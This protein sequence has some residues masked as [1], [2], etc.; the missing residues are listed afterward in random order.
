MKTFDQKSYDLA[1]HFLE[2]DERYEDTSP[3]EKAALAHAL[4][5]DIQQA[6][7]D[8]FLQFEEPAK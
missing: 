3:D 5:C 6:A 7:E 1:L 8:F 4:A 2:G